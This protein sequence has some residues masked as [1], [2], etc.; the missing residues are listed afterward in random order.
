[1]QPHNLTL[2][3]IGAGLLWFGWFGFNG[4]SAGASG[5]TAVTAF[6]A[7]QVAT[8]AAVLSWMLSE[9][10][11]RGKP[12]ALG[13]AS[14]AVAGLVAITPASGYVGPV[15]AIAIGLVAGLLCY[16]AVNFKARLGYDDSLDVVGVHGVGGTWGALATGVF[17][18]KAVN[19]AGADGLLF[20]GL[21]LFGAQLVSIAAAWAYAFVMTVILLKVLDW[22]SGLR[23]TEDQEAEGLDLSQHGESGYSME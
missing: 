21:S 4:G 10:S 2:T 23:V 20:G 7:T 22:T 1:M 15:P 14:G 17:S 19:A 5:A 12:T 3:L 18:S 11:C 6:V 9:W 13:A 8:A 16:K